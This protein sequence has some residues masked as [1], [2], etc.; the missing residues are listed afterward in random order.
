MANELHFPL[1]HGY[2]DRWLVSGVT[3]TP[4]IT[5][6]TALH[7]AENEK[8]NT[9]PKDKPGE[10]QFKAERRAKATAWPAQLDTRPGGLVG[11]A[12]NV[13]PFTVYWPFDDIGVT[14]AWDCETPACLS[15]WAY[16]ELDAAEAGSVPFDL[17]TCGGAALWLNGEKLTE[18]TPYHHNE[19]V[20]TPLTLPLQK[21]RNKLLVFFDNYAERDATIILRLRWK[22]EGAAPEQ[23]IPVGEADAARLAE[24]E[25]LM[26]SLAF[27]RN[28]FTA[29]PV[30]LDYDG[31]DIAESY[32]LA[33]VGGTEENVKGG[34][35]FRREADT[36]P[37]ASQ[38]SLGDCKTFPL[39]FL[40]LQVTTEVEGIR[41]T[42]PISVEIHTESVLPRA[43]PTVAERKRQA[44]ELLA[45]WGEQNTNRALAILATGGDTA[46]AEKLLAVQSDYIRR[47]FDC[48]DFYLVYY[49]YILRTF[50]KRGSGILSEKTENELTDCLLG[51]RYWIDEP[52]NDAMWFW[53]EN[54]ALMFHTCQLLA[55]ELF[56]DE[57]FTNSGLT[58]R[59]MQAKAKNML[60]DWFVTFRK[61]G[62]T[63]WNSSP[64][65]PI[66]TL[67][68]GSLYAFA[69]DPAMRELGREG[70]DF[71]YYLLAVHSQQGIFASSSGR[72]YIKEQF[73]N[74]SNCPSG[75]SWIGYGYG[76]PGHAG[77]GITSYCL[78][79]YEPPKEFAQ[80][81]SIPRGKE[82]ICQTT[83]GNDGYVDLYTYKTADYM[84]TSAND[85]HPGE[86]GHQENPFQLTFNA[87]AQLW[88]THPGERVLFG[89]ARPSYW[90]GNGTLPKV[91]QYKAF[92]GLIYDIAPEHPVDFTHLY[93]PSMEFDR[94]EV[95][96]KWAFVQLGSAYAA[97]YCSNG[98]RMQ[99][100]GSN[101][102][103]ECI[104][105]GRRYR[106]VDP[107]Y[108]ELRCQWGETL[109]VNDAPMQY[110][111]FDNYGK[112]TMQ[113][114]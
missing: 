98:M 111:G 97:V 10:E 25:H 92:A 41:L 114:K 108:G 28:H 110:S 30:L 36:L 93:L 3:E 18:V 21:G 100:F 33:F 35:L 58:G 22:G 70:M 94:C 57:V 83:Q 9:A 19:P 40:L 48:S 60:Y 67:G 26:R 89:A 59:Q 56:P 106:F 109:Y 7:G 75:L 55:G 24:A 82:M 17:I 84:M 88:V 113:E 13:T 112:L 65:L 2:V 74:W 12:D 90:A 29:G 44:L 37:H 85:F 62:F 5:K 86:P 95:E 91:N 4:V 14:Y 50:G 20:P 77:K 54:H 63:E 99:D 79:D 68:F 80:W 27:H 73:G 6:P 87:V 45:R 46:E 64:Y 96:G 1:F 47:R 102:D 42:R 61:E 103:R 15:A 104:A 66:D 72:T 53:S 71:A 49:P 51:F 31:A 107:V 39:A 11:G 32:H 81:F 105:E 23:V 69:Q 78:S 43:L 38:I 52:G 101:K 76:V 34:V 8:L 16:T